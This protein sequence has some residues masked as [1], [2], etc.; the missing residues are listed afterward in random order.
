MRDV[1]PER[2]ARGRAVVR[3]IRRA[4]LP[5]RRAGLRRP[6][7]R[8]QT[9]LAFALLAT[10]PVTSGAQSGR[11][12]GTTL[13][14]GV[15]LR[16]L[17]DDSVAA[18]LATGTG[19]YRQLEDGRL[20]RCVDP[21]PFCRFRRSGSRVLATPLVQDLRATAWGFG[22]GVSAHTHLRARSALG[23]RDLLWPR[24]GDQFDALEAWVQLDRERW[25][26]R[27][28]RQFTSNGLGLYNFDGAS[29]TAHRGNWRLEAFGGLSLVEGLHDWHG[30]DV[31]AEIDDLP[32]DEHGWVLGGRVATVLGGRGA[33]SGTYQR[34]IRTDRASLYSER[35]AGSLSLR[36]MGATIDAGW[37]HDLVSGDVNDA[38]LR[39]ARALPRRLAG[40][41]EVRRHRPFF[42]TWTIWGA[43][44][45]VAFDEARATLG[46]RDP[47]DRLAIDARTAWRRY[48]ETSAGL[49]S[50][51]LRT[52]GWRAGI[53][54]E[55]TP[56]E[57]FLWYGDYDVDIGFGASRSDAT[58]GGRWMPD[59]RRFLGA[60]V[61][62]LENI[63]EFRV[64]T[65]RVLGLRLEGGTGIGQDTRIVVDGALYAHRLTRESPVTDWSQRRFSVRLEWTLGSDPGIGVT[66]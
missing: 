13:M 16:P 48:G 66:R 60:A 57:S 41:L 3:V 7:P 14:Q 55:W 9:W 35:L 4:R 56:R 38:R 18:G 37:I 23:R 65:G 19:P 6:A 39:L 61:T 33:V 11:V 49:E 53:G 51:P 24:A 50:I 64:G 25:R 5:A 44:S 47:S 17:V 54:A 34:V 62:A 42:E 2:V 31:L 32:P 29:V 28:G 58:L 10:L 22:E 52:D 1:S 27:L 45:P 59:E 40:A 26:A 30:G 43:F 21:E 15:D 12:T 63:Y 46:W 36:A 8:G 20:V